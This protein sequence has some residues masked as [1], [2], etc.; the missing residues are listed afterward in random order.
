MW[1]LPVVA[2]LAA[3]PRDSAGPGNDGP[4]QRVASAALEM[5]PAAAVLA[6]RRATLAQRSAGVLVLAA[7]VPEPKPEGNGYRDDGDL[8]YLT[9]LD[10]PGSWLVLVMRLGRVDSATLY[11]PDQAPATGP[12]VSASQITGIRAVRC[13]SAFPGDLRGLFPMIQQPLVLQ[14]ENPAR[15]DPLVDSLHA[16]WGLQRYAYG[17]SQRAV[18]DASEIE[19]LRRAADITSRS[20]VEAV[21]EIR[22]GRTEGDV[23][24]AILARF[25]ARGAPRASFPSIV[26]SGPNA[27][28]A[29]YAGRSRTLANG[30]LVTVDVGAEYGR[31]AGDVTRTFPV[32]GV[33]SPRQKALYELVLATQ[34]VVI[35]SVRPGVTLMHLDSIAMAY[36]RAHSDGL[37]G[38]HTCEEYDTYYIGHGL[39]LNVHDVLWPAQVL[40][41]G[42]VLTV[43]PRIALPADSLAIQIEDVVLVTATG[44]EILSS[45]APRSVQDVEALLASVFGGTVGVS[46]ARMR[47]G[48]SND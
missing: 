42:T 48:K 35:D 33:F 32:G 16:L 29:H 10:L 24:A 43:E 44:R 5:P 30:E 3:C 21:A 4:C 26:G 38:A 37:C 20:I 9:G 19:R 46:P 6:Q 40:A 7:G 27:L 23:A 15:L 28:D 41:P 18:K 31:Y 47:R 45:A 8:Y 2:V 13:A 34:Q 22:T 11:L 14:W 17:L 1:W 25:A 39:G 12:T 36:M